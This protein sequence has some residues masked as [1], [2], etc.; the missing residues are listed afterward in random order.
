M[1]NNFLKHETGKSTYRLVLKVN[2]PKPVLRFIMGLLDDVE[3]VGSF[4]FQEYLLSHIGKLFIM[5]P[6]EYSLGDED[7]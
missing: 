5:K 3:V 1:V 7:K 6:E 2:N 4:E